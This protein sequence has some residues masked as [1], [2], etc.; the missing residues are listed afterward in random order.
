MFTKNRRPAAYILM[1]IFF[2]LGLMAKPMLVTLPFIL[3]LLDFW[4]SGRLQKRQSVL[5]SLVLEKL[6]LFAL[7]ALSC[8][9]TLAIEAAGAG[10]TLEYLPLKTR[11]ANASVAYI[12]YILKIFYPVKLAVFYPHIGQ[13]LPVWQSVVSI[14]ILLVISILIIR[15]AM[16]YKYLLTGWL[17]FIGTLIPVIGIV[18][19][20]T[21]SHADRYTYI[22]LTGLFIMIAWGAPELLAKWRYKRIVLGTAA[23]VIIAA[24]SVAAFFQTRLWQN[25]YSLYTHTLKA[26][27]PNTTIQTNLGSYLQTK[28]RLE[29]AITHYQKALDIRPSNSEALYSFAT[30]LAEKSDLK[31][32]QSYYQKALYFNPDHA[33]ANYNLALLLKSQGN[34]DEAI[35]Y[36]RRAIKADPDLAEAHNTLANILA[37]KGLLD[38]AITHYRKAL[39]VQPNYIAA[40]HNLANTLQTKGARDAAAVHFRKALAIYPDYVPS[41]VALAQILTDTTD[42]NMYNAYEAIALAERAAELTSFSNSFALNTLA[43]SYAS[44][45]RFDKAVTTA[46]KALELAIAD[47]D[48]DFIKYIKNKIN[49]YEN[50]ST[51]INQ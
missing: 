37:L 17:W 18:Q 10:T 49:S 23:V 12:T 44:A 29:E 50:Q 5:F 22:P 19:V 4:P 24:F 51:K 21:Q 14:L 16:K 13:A 35:E 3:L 2:A 9:I 7:S 15:F 25:C 8:I 6:P 27:R 31:R 43:D 38:D 28:G 36:F 20:G 42:P 47:N 33:N 48:P 41:L 30:A 11:L 26:T 32:A 46:K 39:E 34:I 45:G 1:I 40:H